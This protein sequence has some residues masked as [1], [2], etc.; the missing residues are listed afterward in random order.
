MWYG[1]SVSFPMIHDSH[2]Q[3]G[4]RSVAFPVFILLIECLYSSFLDILY[5]GLTLTL[6]RDMPLLS[7]PQCIFGVYQ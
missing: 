1:T 6:L 5:L 4:G 7:V 2:T 3:Y